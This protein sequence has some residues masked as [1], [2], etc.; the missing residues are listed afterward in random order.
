MIRL[1]GPWSDLGTG[2]RRQEKKD[3]LVTAAKLK[4]CGCELCSTGQRGLPDN[5]MWC[6]IGKDRY[7]VQRPYET[8]S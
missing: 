2:P 8:Q 5:V 1:H 3:T 7:I 4:Q 6:R